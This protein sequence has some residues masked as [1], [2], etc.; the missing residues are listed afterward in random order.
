MAFKFLE[1]SVTF[2]KP[3]SGESNG[4]AEVEFDKKII[5]AEVGI[6][7]WEIQTTDSDALHQVGAT[8]T[9]VEIDYATNKVTVYACLIFRGYWHSIIQTSSMKIVV[10][11]WCED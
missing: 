2:Y 9:G 10:F 6:S 3:Q 11:A 5:S 1:K 7:Q 4:M 8:I